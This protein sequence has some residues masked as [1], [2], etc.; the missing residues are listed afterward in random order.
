VYD[1]IFDLIG[2]VI[3]ILVRASRI[4][5][6]IDKDDSRVDP[7][8][9][10]RIQIAMRQLREEAESSERPTPAQRPQPVP[11]Y[12]EEGTFAGRPLPEKPARMQPAA[13]TIKERSTDIESRLS[14][15]QKLEE[16]RKG[17]PVPLSVR[18]A[19][20]A[21]EEEALSVTGFERPADEYSFKEAIPL[22]VALAGV[23]ERPRVAALRLG[24][25]QPGFWV[26]AVIA[27]EVLG[28]PP[29]LR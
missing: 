18:L 13:A 16:M 9:W 10:K 17:K 8:F 19:Y 6:E 1:S 11:T 15:Q 20:T 25:E 28:P 21:A 2:W 7:G 26:R 27:Q 4:K 12:S 29:A 22:N 24:T 3:R 23:E 5:Q 14:M